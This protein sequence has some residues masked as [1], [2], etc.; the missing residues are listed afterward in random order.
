MIKNIVFSGGGIK[1]Y[2]FIGC[3]KVLEEKDLL[4]N[5]DTMIGTSA[6]SIIATLLCLGFNATEIEELLLRIDTNSLKTF[7][8]NNILN[9]FN[10]YGIDDGKNIRRIISI[11]FKVKFKKDTITF[12][13]LYEITNKKLIICTTCLNT[14]EPEYLSFETTPEL[15]IDEA[16][17]MSISIPLLFKPVLYKDNYYID[18]GLTNH[19][20]INY[21][22]DVNNETL[23]VLITTTINKRQEIN[24]IEDYLYNI[25]CCSNCKL[26]NDC[27]SLYKNNTILIENNFNFMDFNLEYEQKVEFINIGYTTAEKYINSAEFNEYYCNDK[28]IIDKN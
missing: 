3:I 1:L 14:N 27:Y 19:Y 7:D 9:F 18:G 6:G 2:S 16:I 23:G 13:E 4:Q 5:I 20:P 15:N 10:N 12:K 26:I 21:C 22:G 8:T 17:I 11:L 24:N 28:E 25:L